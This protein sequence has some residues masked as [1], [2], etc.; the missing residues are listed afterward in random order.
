MKF[1]SQVTLDMLYNRSEFIYLIFFVQYLVDDIVKNQMEA[2][3]YMEDEDIMLKIKDSQSEGDKNNEHK[4]VNN[5]FKK[6]KSTV[7]MEEIPEQIVMRD[8]ADYMC[9]LCTN[10]EEKFVGDAKE[11]VLHVKNIHDARLYVCD[12]CGLD[13]KKRNELSVH[14]DDHVAKEEGDFQCE[15]CNRIF[16]N[17]RLFRIHK[18]SHYPQVKSWPCETCGKRYR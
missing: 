17:L 10:D 3:E 18:R 7:K 6:G 1:H 5:Q 4:K 2:T 9:L 11:I 13:F 12:I 14:L 15:V 16:S 8:G